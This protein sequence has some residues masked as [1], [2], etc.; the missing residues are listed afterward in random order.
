MQSMETKSPRTA[1]IHS[2]ASGLSIVSITIGGRNY[3]LYRVKHFEGRSM[4]V[5][6]GAISFPVG[7]HLEING[8]KQQIPQHPPFH[9]SATVVENGSNGIR[10][11]W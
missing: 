3:G 10:L 6:Y 2:E 4:V 5:G 1:Q 11:V 8:F 9:Q 7:T